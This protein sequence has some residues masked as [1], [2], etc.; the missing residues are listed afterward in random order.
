MMKREARQADE[1]EITVSSCLSVRLPLLEEVVAFVV[2]DD[3]RW[4]VL[5]LHA[6]D[7]LHA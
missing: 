5:D 1:Q 2:D 6:P 7:R 4:E 3:E